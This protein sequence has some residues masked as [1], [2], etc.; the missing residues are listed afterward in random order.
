M[1]KENHLVAM[2]FVFDEQFATISFG[3]RC[4]PQCGQLVKPTTYGYL[5]NSRV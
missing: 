1:L 2:T 5:F 3:A 4:D